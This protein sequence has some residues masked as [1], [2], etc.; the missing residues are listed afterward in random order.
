MH[1]HMARQRCLDCKPL[2]AFLAHKVLGPRMRRRVILQL[3]LGHETSPTAREG[4]D[5]WFVSGMRM[6]MSSEFGFVAEGMPGCA[7]E[8]V[9]VVVGCRVLWGCRAAGMNGADVG[10][11]VGG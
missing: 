1:I 8:P 2:P 3:L 4:A 11:E 10:V 6:D 7:A 9:A 5:M